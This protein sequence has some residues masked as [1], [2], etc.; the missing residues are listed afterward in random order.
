MR[1]EIA[2]QKRFTESFVMSVSARKRR[3]FP[4]VPRDDA[5]V[6]TQKCVP[7]TVTA[8][9][10]NVARA[11]LNESHQLLVRRVKNL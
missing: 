3:R 8:P 7:G 11:A 4:A 10:P 6:R 2:Q 1:R 9:W 5:K